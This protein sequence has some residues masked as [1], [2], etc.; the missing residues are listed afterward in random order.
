MKLPLPPGANVPVAGS[1]VL[2]PVVQPCSRATVPSAS[3]PRLVP[4]T[5]VASG[6]EAGKPADGTGPLNEPKLLPSPPSPEE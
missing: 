2:V 3:T 6:D 5:A 1:N 4:P